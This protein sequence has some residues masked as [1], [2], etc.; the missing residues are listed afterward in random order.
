MDARTPVT[1]ATKSSSTTRVHKARSGAS[2]VGRWN[3]NRPTT[4]ATW[5]DRPQ[6]DPWMAAY[7]P[8]TEIIK[9]HQ[10]LPLFEG[11]I[12]GD[13]KDIKPIRDFILPDSH[14]RRWE[15]LV[16]TLE[17]FCKGADFALE[18]FVPHQ[19]P[20]Q[21]DQCQITAWVSDRNENTQSPS[22]PLNNERD[23]SAPQLYKV[24]QQK[25]RR[26]AIPPQSEFVLRERNH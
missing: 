7:S 10:D 18:N 17:N 21:D 4:V 13:E 23:L 11:A 3:T 1:K 19:L 14:S 24:L 16:Q 5:I 12:L 9:Q 2:V 22:A 6:P 8:K 15:H 25:V 26:K 20:G